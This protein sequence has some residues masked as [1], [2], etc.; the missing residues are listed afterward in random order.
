VLTN[1]YTLRA[2]VHEWHPR[3]VGATLIDSYSQHKGSLILVFEEGTGESWSINISIQT[4]HRHLFMYGGSNRS[5]KNVVDQFSS[6]KGAVLKDV[7]IAE[8][9]RLITFQFESGSALVVAAFGPKANVFHIDNHGNLKGTFKGTHT[10]SV[11]EARGTEA[12]LRAEDLKGMLQSGTSLNGA[13]PL[14]PAPLISEIRSLVGVID[15]PEQIVDAARY[16]TSLLDKPV[17]RI[18]WN[19]NRKP[20]LSMIPLGWVSDREELFDTADEA[21]RVCARRRLAMGLFEGA[22]NPLIRMLRNRRDQADRSMKRVEGELGSPSRADKHE[23]FGHLLMA[24]PHLVENG[25]SEVLMADIL[26]D[27]SEVLIRLDHRLN[28]FENAQRYFEK[29]KNSRVARSSAN[30]RLKGL[31]EKAADVTDLLEKALSLDTVD[32]VKTFQTK[33]ASRLQSL[34]SAPDDPDSVPFRRYTLA[35]GYEVW[36]GKNAKQND[37]LT[38]KVA[39]KFDLWLHARGVAGSHTVLRIKGRTDTPPRTILEQAA[40]IAAWHS[41]ART[42]ALAPVIITQR[43]YVRK[44]RKSLPGTVI[45]ERG[46]VILVEPRLPSK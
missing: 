19:E 43:K 16:I 37:E 27:G 15:D 36:V 11:P 23:H 2:L 10:R 9:D 26:D 14:F 5:R 25:A 13:F 44:P 12:P 20:L 34:K 21:V 4:P 38:L 8:G 31:R 28:S 6:L 29:A 3:L 32:S 40:A 17:P 7:S 22:Y 39:R 42:S 24:Q 1:Y 18:Y 30:D 35:D 41:K 45:V 46:K 33:Y